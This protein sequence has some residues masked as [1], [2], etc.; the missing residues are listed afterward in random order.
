M[1]HEREDFLTDALMST[2]QDERDSA[3]ELV[4]IIDQLC[5]IP[6]SDLQSSTSDDG[7]E[8][9]TLIATPDGKWLRRISPGEGRGD[10]LIVGSEVYYRSSKGSLRV[11]I[12][13]DPDLKTPDRRDD[14]DRG[15]ADYLTLIDP[16]ADVLLDGVNVDG[17][18][19]RKITYNLK[20]SGNRESYVI[21][22]QRGTHT[23]FKDTS[24]GRESE[25]TLI[26]DAVAIGNQQHVTQLSPTDTTEAF[27]RIGKAYHSI[28]GAVIQGY[29]QAHQ[30]IAQNFPQ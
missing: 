17:I 12:Y 11:T 1:Q 9:F 22:S 4:A 21:I 25:R 13:T 19:A 14:R 26:K 6:R 5:E 15:L 8:R 27:R 10:N 2:E 18:V 30:R 7:G 24:R 28:A 16:D 20:K 3:A 23:V 29:K